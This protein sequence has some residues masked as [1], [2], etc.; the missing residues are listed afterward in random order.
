MAILKNPLLKGYS[1]HIEKTVVVKQYTDKIVLTAFPDMSNI[2]F[3]E[4]QLQEQS[5]MARAAAFASAV[6]KD[7]VQ[8]A[9]WA[10]RFPP[11][12]SIYH[13]IIAELLRKPEKV[14]PKVMFAS[15]SVI[16]RQKT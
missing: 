13:S 1:G 3:T 16:L 8:K 6:V 12:A 7:P 15:G 11:G 10:A 4:S 14:Q 5:R 9:A 2:V